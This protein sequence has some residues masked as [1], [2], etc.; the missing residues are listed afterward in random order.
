QYARQE[1]AGGIAEALGLAREFVG[2][3]RFV[4]MLA[5]NVYGGSI[6]PTIANFKAQEHGARGLLAHVRGTE[7][8]RHLGGPGVR[9][10]RIARIEEKPLD[11]P[12][13]L[14]VTGLYCYEPDVF[15]V[16]AELEPSGRGELEITDVNN[17]FAREGT[18]EYDV[19]A[20]YWGDAGESIP[21]YY[22]VIDRFRR[23]RN[24]HFRGDRM[25][26]IALPRFH[27]EPGS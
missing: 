19:F 7:H 21:T 22:E 5:D 6:A 23:T 24:S 17:H 8:P 25:E 20:G 13:R 3:E 2:D 1:R 15:D 16:V 9:E 18:L 11:P 14:A 4:V 12:G 26:A 10:G 27:H